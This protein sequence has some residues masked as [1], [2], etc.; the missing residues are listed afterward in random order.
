MSWSVWDT[1]PN[2]EDWTLAEV[3]YDIGHAQIRYPVNKIDK[4]N[5]RVWHFLSVIIYC[6]G[7]GSSKVSWSASDTFPNTEGWTLAILAEVQYDIGHT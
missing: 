3:Q 6:A 2:I 5:Y 1:F 7:I 4:Y